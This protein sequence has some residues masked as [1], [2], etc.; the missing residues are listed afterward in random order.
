MPQSERYFNYFK[1]IEPD[2]WHNV[3][4]FAPNNPDQFI[5]Y[6]AQLPF[7]GRMITKD[8]LEFKIIGKI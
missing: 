2:K 8:K 6:L 1:T 7:T 3:K 4:D 5:K